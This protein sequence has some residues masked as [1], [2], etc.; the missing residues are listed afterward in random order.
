VFQLN[1]VSGKKKQKLAYA[2]RADYLRMKRNR[3]KMLNEWTFSLLNDV[4]GSL[5]MNIK[6]ATKKHV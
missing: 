5:K 3:D 2:I 4:A 1:L 6:E